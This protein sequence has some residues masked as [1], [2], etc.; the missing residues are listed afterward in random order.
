MY[1][2]KPPDFQFIH[3]NSNVLAETQD[4][5]E[6]RLPIPEIPYPNSLF[7]KFVGIL[8]VVLHN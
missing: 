3:N 2:E 1:V 8:K 7:E 5:M 6:Q 4:I